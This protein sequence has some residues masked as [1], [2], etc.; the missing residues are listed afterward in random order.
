MADSGGPKWGAIISTVSAAATLGFGIGAYMAADG[1][2]STLF[3]ECP[4]MISCDSL[5]TP[6]RT[7]DAVALA[8][9]IG[10]AGLTALAIVLWVK[11][12]S[13]RA[14]TATTTRINVGPGGLSV[15]GSF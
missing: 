4:S 3:A 13:A 11:P 2:Q 5:K 9:F 6:V 15:S 7:W 1:A 10:A 14:A 8:S 12:S